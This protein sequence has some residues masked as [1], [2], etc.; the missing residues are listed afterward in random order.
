[1]RVGVNLLW[2]RPAVVGGSEQYLCRLLVGLAELAPPDLEVV[3]AALPSFRGAH[4]EVASRL[5]VVDAPTSGAR[6]P[7]RVATEATW[8]AA[9]SRR[10][11]LDLVHHAGGT[12]PVVL[13]APGALGVH[14]LQYL[15][16]PET[17][18][19]VK[20]AY[21][22]SSLP[23]SARRA[24]VVTVPSEYVRGTVVDGLGVDAA[25]VHVVPH[26]IPD[27]EVVATPV[28]EGEVR[29]RYDLPGPFFLYP[30][31]TYAHKN[32][33]AVVRALARLGPEHH[34]ARLVLL[35]GAGPAEEEV[36][37]EV[38]RLGLGERVVRPGRVPDGDRNG[39]YRAATATV[40]P[41]RYEGFGAPALE[42]MRLGCP[43]VAAD[44]TA[45]PEVVG[46]AGLLVGPDDVA[47][48]AAAMERLLDDGAERL[49]LRAAGLA[50]ARGLGAERSAAALV[51]AYRAGSV[52]P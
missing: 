9:W 44:A 39:L 27:D 16:Y 24:R 6:R 47:G 42:A 12:M 17:F 49:R 37:A 10:R 52:P 13:G 21:L 11:R 51:A 34:A 36:A 50:R 40:F 33:V 5:E 31:I 1:V 22:R 14:D 20:L 46:E 4:P 48:W 41:S 43:L 29:R 30:A 38:A 23:R 3:V 25:K 19:R 28:P 15:T 18:S 35:G 2:L 32:H 26:G 45:L 7:L 8:L